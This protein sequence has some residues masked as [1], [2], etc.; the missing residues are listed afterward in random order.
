MKKY[1]KIKNKRGEKTNEKTKW[2]NIDSI[3]NNNSTK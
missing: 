3:S 1:N 2:N